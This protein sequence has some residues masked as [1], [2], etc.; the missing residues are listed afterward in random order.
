VG[1]S[2][3]AQS[4]T[5]QLADAVVLTYH[6]LADENYSTTSARERKY[7]MTPCRFRQQIELLIYE[8]FQCMTLSGFWDTRSPGLDRAVVMTFD[9]GRAS[10]YE[11]AFPILLESG[12]RATLFV[13]TATIGTSGYLTWPQIDEMRRHGMSIES[14][15]HDHVYLSELPKTELRRQL[16]V[17]KRTVEDR[18]G[19]PVRF[20][21]TP[22]GDTNA[23]V[24][25]EALNLG[26]SALCTSGNR[27]ARAG[28][29]TVNRVVVYG[30]TT[31]VEFR[32]LVNRDT[33]FYFARAVR[34]GLLYVPKEFLGVS[35]KVRARM[36]PEASA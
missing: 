10:D 22:Y 20:L 16:E 2:Q 23:L 29:L 24:L 13:N 15:S 6:G 28:S 34:A 21:A 11:R 19:A 5:G 4:Q 32:R 9:D 26:Y 35:R 1:T 8:E 33:F 36:S 7:W 17:S 3:L 18:L 12:I 31:D 30:T 25:M 14:H 27:P